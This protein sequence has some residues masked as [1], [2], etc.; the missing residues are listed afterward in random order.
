VKAHH[1]GMTVASIA[2]TQRF[3]STHFGFIP[4]K[5]EPLLISDAWF[6]EGIEREGAQLKVAWIRRDDAVIELHEYVVPADA[7]RVKP[8][9]ENVGAPHIAFSVPDIDTVYSRLVDDGIRFY[10]PPKEVAPEGS[11]GG[12]L[13]GIKWCYCEDPNGYIVEIFSEPVGGEIDWAERMA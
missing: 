2:D 12:A 10:S 13:G 5:Q 4:S 1:F 9:I 11:A 7:P 6:G 8:H 3:Y